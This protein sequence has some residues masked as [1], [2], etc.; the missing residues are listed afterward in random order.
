[1]L[2]K[3]VKPNDELKNSINK[4]CIKN[5]AKFTRPYEFEYLE[6]LPKT[7]TNKIDYKK[8]EE[9]TLKK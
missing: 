3:G 1:M 7:T 8:L 2:N 4:H 6:K 9:Y 5:L